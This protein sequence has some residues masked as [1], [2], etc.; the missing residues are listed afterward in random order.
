MLETG[1]IKRGGNTIKTECNE[2]KGNGTDRKTKGRIQQIE[3]E[4]KNKTK[5]KGKI[6]ENKTRQNKRRQRTNRNVMNK[7]QKRHPQAI[8]AEYRD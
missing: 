5:Q 8:S 6:T 3:D 4:T 7:E 2:Q 1:K